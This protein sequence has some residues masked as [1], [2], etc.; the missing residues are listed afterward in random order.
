VP[1]ILAKARPRRGSGDVNLAAFTS[2]CAATRTA[3]GDRCNW[4]HPCRRG[5]AF[6]GGNS[7]PSKSV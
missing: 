7:P 2:A 1:L 5:D 3:V 6:P 4:N